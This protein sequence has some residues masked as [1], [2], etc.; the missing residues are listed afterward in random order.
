MLRSQT[1]S[2]SA[3]LEDIV[4]GAPGTQD[5]RAT[6]GSATDWYAVVATFRAVGQPL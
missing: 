5:A 6:F 2:G 4:A 3:D 1:E